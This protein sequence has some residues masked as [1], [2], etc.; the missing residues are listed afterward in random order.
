MTASNYNFSVIDNEK[1]GFELL[2]ASTIIP[3]ST[4][5]NSY[6]G[7]QSFNLR[8]IIRWSCF[9]HWRPSIFDRKWDR[10]WGRRNIYWWKGDGSEILE[11]IKMIIYCE[12]NEWQLRVTT[13]GLEM[14]M[15]TLFL[16]SQQFLFSSQF[17][18]C[19]TNSLLLEAFKKIF[20]KQ[21]TNEMRENFL[22]VLC[23]NR[24]SCSNFHAHLELWQI[25]NSQEIFENKSSTNT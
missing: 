21:H 24:K 12:N 22:G 6:S 25:L 14:L 15:N 9:Y 16:Y 23:R 4:S 13:M 2:F 8:L 3:S 17:F 11:W 5:T 19:W 7:C 1:L 18:A 10:S 20:S